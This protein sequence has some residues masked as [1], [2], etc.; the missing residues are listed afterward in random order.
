MHAAKVTRPRIVLVNRCLIRNAENQLLIIKRIDDDRWMGGKWE[1]PGGKLDINDDINIA[2][3]REVLEETNLY[4]KITSILSYVNLSEIKT[5]KYKGLPYIEIVR[6]AEVIGNSKIKLS[7]EHSEYIWV[8][9]EDV[10]DYDLTQETLKALK[11]L[12]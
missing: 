6:K 4:V 8:S 10:F 7:E 11:A 2:I 3:E 5:G 1:L 12:I 9:D